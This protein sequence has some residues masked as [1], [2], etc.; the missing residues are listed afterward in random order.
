[1]I[2]RSV[3]DRQLEQEQPVPGDRLHPVEAVET[4]SFVVDERVVRKALAA[5]DPVRRETG[6]RILYAL[7]PLAHRDV[8]EWMREHLDGV[9]ASSLFEAKLAR[10]VLGSRKIV[11]VTTPCFRDD[12]LEPLAELCDHVVLNSLSQWERFRSR[13][14]GRASIGLRVNPGLSFVEDARYDPCRRH[15]KL[16]A[17]LATLVK[18]LADAPEELAGLAGLH[19]HTNC[20]SILFEP[21]LRIVHLLAKR[22]DPLLQ[23]LRWINL[24]GGYHFSTPAEFGPLYEAID[25]L[26]E[27]YPVTVYL[28]PGATLVREAGYLVASVTDLFE[29]DGAMIAVLDTSV[30]HAPEVFEYQFRPEVIGDDPDHPLAYLLAGA[31]C[32]AGDLF[33]EYRFLEPLRIGSRV[34]FPQMGAYT[35]V[36]AHTF[37][38]INLPSLY[39]ITASGALHLRRRFDY[40]DYLQ[41]MG[42]ID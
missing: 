23:S 42:L 29:A 25:F 21:L 10:E 22:L 26:R 18:V 39:T 3:S 16:G 36:K 1:M 7:K 41:R 34:I 37:N 27:R 14:R 4:P 40:D 32:L 13:L 30:N 35:L 31:T 2:A 33:G 38:G 17:P 11:S 24:G 20:D 12:E 15:S 5:V 19:F 6:A 8:L 28:E 9:A